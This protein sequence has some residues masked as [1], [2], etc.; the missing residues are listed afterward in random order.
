MMVM[1]DQKLLSSLF[2][3]W[4]DV[5]N[6]CCHSSESMHK[7]KEGSLHAA[8]CFLFVQDSCLSAHFG[9][10]EC[11]V[12]QWENLSCEHHLSSVTT[13]L[14]VPGSKWSTHPTRPR[15]S[16]AHVRTWCWQ[17]SEGSSSYWDLTGGLNSPLHKY[18]QQFWGNA[19]CGRI[20]VPI[21]QILSESRAEPITCLLFPF[22][23]GR[24]QQRPSSAECVQ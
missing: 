3:L 19:L 16:P 5:P 17:C 24:L 8:L 20:Q 7:E 23:P 10:L 4:L 6:S 15:H 14:A 9:K 12:T 2:A 22:T 21:N 13:C 18:Q 1:F 11:S